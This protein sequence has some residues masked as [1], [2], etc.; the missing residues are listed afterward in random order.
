VKAVVS[1]SGT[2]MTLDLPDKY[3]GKI[4]TIYVGTTV[5]GKTTY[6]KIDFFALDTEDGTASITTKVKL[7]KGQIIRVNVGSTVVKS[8]KI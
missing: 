6:R 5:K 1:K 2:K 8:V 7:V 4:V 3:L